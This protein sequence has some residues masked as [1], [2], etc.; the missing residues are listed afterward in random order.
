MRLT[1]LGRDLPPALGGI[2]DHTDLLASELAGRGVE[3]T[4]VCSPPAG[5]HEAYAVVPAVTRWDLGGHA[6]I[7][8]AVAATDPDV[9][10]WQYNPFNL[11]RR[12][13]PLGASRLARA[14]RRRAG[15]VVFAH[16][17][18]FPWGR[19]GARGLAW[20]VMQRAESRGVLRAADACIVTTEDREAAV[21]ALDVRRLTRLPVGTTIVPTSE[22]RA[23]ARAALDL[24]D[25]V[26]VL[27]HLGGL[28]PG[29]DPGPVLAA[30]RALREHG[31]RPFVLLAGDTGPF[32]PPA[33]LADQIR[34]TG[35]VDRAELSRALTAA[36]VYLHMDHAGAS[37]GRRTS[38]GAAMAHGLA[39]LSY[40]GPQHAPQLVDRRNV[41][42]VEPEPAAIADA[43][44]AFRDGRL[45]A[46]A[47]GA[48][49]RATFDDHSSWTRIGDE[50]LRVCTDAAA[51][52]ARG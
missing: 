51:G 17:L 21:R 31:V 5:P 23:A 26:L 8:G 6:A 4:V 40:R 25:D 1:I 46:E 27:A 14:L 19:E 45:D 28:G 20:A 37:M 42:L 10:L 22:G 16:E 32:T 39:I 50:V 35:I 15:L 2:G 36:D 11:G 29:R 9:V 33:D 34:R 47:L 41:V 38:L 7:L 24:P 52:R 30:L 13:V 12:G 48:A 44:R 3:V 43:I 18:W 49:A